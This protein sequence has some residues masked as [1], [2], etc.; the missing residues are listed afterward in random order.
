MKNAYKTIE[1]IKKKGHCIGL[2]SKVL[3]IEP[4]VLLKNKNETVA[5]LGCAEMSCENNKFSF[6]HYKSDNFFL[7]LEKLHKLAD[8]VIISIH[9]G[10]EQN[11]VPSPKQ[12]RFAKQCMNNH[13][14]LFIGKTL[15]LNIYLHLNTSY[16]HYHIIILK[17]G[18]HG[19]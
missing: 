1:Y 11:F 5:V 16:F 9:W 14:S 12:R 4:Y 6:L 17:I 7:I 10:D 18:K 2:I 19:R 15:M 13:T 8:K 3:K